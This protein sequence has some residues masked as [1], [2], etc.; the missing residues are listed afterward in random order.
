MQEGAAEGRREAVDR[1]LATLVPE[2]AGAAARL[3]EAARYALLAPGKRIRPLLA[4]AAA[5]HWGGDPS[6]A[7]DAG[8]AV[9]MVHAASLI[10]DDLPSM[11]DAALRR[12]RATVH[13]VYGEDL[14]VLAA[15]ALLARAFG[16][17][18]G[19]STIAP[20]AR[21]RLS[22][23]LAGAVGF[24]GLTAGQTR[25]L[26]QRNGTGLD[27][28]ALLNRQKTGLLFEL[29]AVA[30][31]LAA[32]ADGQVEAARR[33]GERLGAAFQIRDDLLDVEAEAALTGKDAGQDGDKPTVVS[34]LGA[35]GARA[36]LATEL[37]AAQAAA[38]D[39]PLMRL[40]QW[41]FPG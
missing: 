18:S 27:D 36:R 38:G 25:D 7:L 28:L 19:P 16:V 41:S 24:E 1:R 29:A 35:E 31:A 14:A 32:G 34:L 4:M 39:G 13:R 9:E 33:F 3:T 2:T 21:L 11:D 23:E 5:E 6:A 12:G 37:S 30:G 22:A 40:A 26:H 15:V 10:L 20:E 17:L 8:C